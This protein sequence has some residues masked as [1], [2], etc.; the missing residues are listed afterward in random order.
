MSIIIL[1]LITCYILT[2]LFSAQW[3][4]LQLTIL[5]FTKKQIPTSFTAN[6]SISKIIHNLAYNDDQY[7]YTTIESNLKNFI[8][9]NCIYYQ[10]LNENYKTDFLKRAQSFINDK[11]FI[12]I[13]NCNIHSDEI[14]TIAYHATILSFGFKHY[15]YDE[16]NEI[17]ISES[18]LNNTIYN[19]K[20]AGYTSTQGHFYFSKKAIHDGMKNQKDGYNILFHEFAHGLS[21]QAMLTGESILNEELYKQWMKS[22]S[23]YLDEI[24]SGK[25]EFLRNYAFTNYPEFF[26]VSVESFFERSEEYKIHFPSHYQA[27][28]LLLNQD[29][30]QTNNPIL[31]HRNQY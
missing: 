4:Q 25:K 3:F 6:N 17:Y 2:K 8:E 18:S 1:I 23:T 28:C 15:L 31:K 14:Y 21:V 29:T 22:C 30:L 20:I 12:P 26:A 27:M 5:H 16:F 7:L 10:Q 11:D 13:E 24:E 9:K 19:K